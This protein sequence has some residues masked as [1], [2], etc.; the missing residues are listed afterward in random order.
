MKG[1]LPGIHIVLTM[2]TD[3]ISECARWP[4]LAMALNKTA[5]LLRWMTNDELREAIAAPALLYRGKVE[6]E[7]V[8]RIIRDAGGNQDQLPVIEHA[9]MWMWDRV[10]KSSGAVLTLADYLSPEVGGIDGALSRHAD[11]IYESLASSEVGQGSPP[12]DL[13]WVAQRLF[14]ALT[15]V[16]AGGRVIRR[17]CPFGDLSATIGC[18][19]AELLHVINA[20]RKA[21]CSFL[22]PPENTQIKDTDRIDVSHEALIRQWSKMKDAKRWLEEERAGRPGLAIAGW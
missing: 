6:P 4:R 2:R 16:D 9:L 12:P 13:R 18:Q 10:G 5:Y 22:M 15:D 1:K 19:P 17:P 11:Q 7:L 3:F 21:G 8:E 14:Q 20:F